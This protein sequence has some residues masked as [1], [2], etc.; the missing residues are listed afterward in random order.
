MDYESMGYKMMPLKLTIQNSTFC[1]GCLK[2]ITDAKPAKIRVHMDDNQ[3]ADF[4]TTHCVTKAF[5][6]G[7]L[8]MKENLNGSDGTT[9]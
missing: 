7:V 6:K 3:F 1:L 5:I 4:H 2:D 9:T 8:Y